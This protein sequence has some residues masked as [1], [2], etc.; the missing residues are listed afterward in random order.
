[1]AD[2]QANPYAPTKLEGPFADAI[3]PTIVSAPHQSQQGFSGWAGK[4]GNLL[5]VADK[6]LAG[7]GQ[8]RMMAALANEK[9]KAKTTS[10]MM[11]VYQ[12]LVNDPRVDDVTKATFG[13]KFQQTLFSEAA[14]DIKKTKG[15]HPILDAMGHIITGMAGGEV[16]KSKQDPKAMQSL[17]GEMAAARVEAAKK[18]AASGASGEPLLNA[19]SKEI[20]GAQASGKGVNHGDITANMLAKYPQLISDYDRRFGKDS[21]VKFIND[22]TQRLAAPPQEAKLTPSSNARRMPLNASANRRAASNRSSNR[23]L[24]ELRQNRAHL[25]TLRCASGTELPRR[26]LDFRHRRRERELRS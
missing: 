18:A 17:M 22:T 13:Q 23:S 2:Q 25:S 21:G 9:E 11:G 12:E 19:I 6:F 8:G 3:D 1:M 4:T 7:L 20:Q 16:K 26:S 10:A 14:T 24:R 5:G 15:Q